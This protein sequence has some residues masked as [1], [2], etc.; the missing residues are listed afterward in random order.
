MKYRIL[1]T[2]LLVASL[3]ALAVLLGDDGPAKPGAPTPP[4]YSTN[5]DEKALKGLSIP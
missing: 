1:A 3:A 2:L 4:G 5:T